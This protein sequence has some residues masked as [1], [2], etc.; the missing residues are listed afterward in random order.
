MNTDMRIFMATQANHTVGIRLNLTEKKA[1]R[2]DYNH[3][4]VET[5]YSALESVVSEL[6]S[7]DLENNTLPLQLFVND[8]LYKNIVNGYYKYW[9]LTGKTNEG[10]KIDENEIT[11]WEMFNELYSKHNLKIIIKSTTEAKISDRLKAMEGKFAT[12]GRNKGKRITISSAQ[13]NNDK[14]STYCW[15]EL[16]KLIGDGNEIIEEDFDTAEMQG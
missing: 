8:H 10:E 5:R 15:T 13:K 3:E 11:L 9:I 6:N 4:G 16:K 2:F 14:Y 12:K 7:F 1:K